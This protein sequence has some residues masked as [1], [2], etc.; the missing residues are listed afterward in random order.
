MTQQM[1]QLSTLGRGWTGGWKELLPTGGGKD[2][3]EQQEP[4]ADSLCPKAHFCSS[5][6][7]IGTPFPPLHKTPQLCQ[8]LSFYSLVKRAPPPSSV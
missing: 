3:Q 5:H 4:P 7:G 6:G 2:W 1:W 8:L